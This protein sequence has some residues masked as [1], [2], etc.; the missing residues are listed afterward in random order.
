MQRNKKGGGR[1]KKGATPIAYSGRNRGRASEICIDLQPERY[2]EVPTLFLENIRARDRSFIFP[3]LGVNLT[4]ARYRLHSGQRKRE[5]NTAC[6]SMYVYVYT[7]YQRPVC[8]PEGNADKR[9]SATKS[10]R[11]HVHI[12][13][14][15][16]SKGAHVGASGI[17]ARFPIDP[18]K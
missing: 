10:L 17:H 7:R 12:L 8:V 13:A 16:N 11:A 15:T 3:D 2:S 4:L 5:K 9:L 1:R 18:G 6:I 14:I